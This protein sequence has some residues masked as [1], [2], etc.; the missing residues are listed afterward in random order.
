VFLRRD[1]KD[2]MEITEKCNLYRALFVNLL[3]SPG[4]DSQPGG[5]V[6]Q[7]YLTYRHA[8]LH[9]LAESISGLLK[10]FTNTGSGGGEWN[11]YQ[12]FQLAANFFG[13]NQMG[14][15]MNAIKGA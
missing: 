15:S 9:R 14:L 5:S 3:K 13:I 4:I 8:M 12:V 1:Y 7:S 11:M 2:S 6:R 10:R